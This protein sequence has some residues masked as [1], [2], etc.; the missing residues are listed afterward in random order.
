ME[1]NNVSD[2]NAS[3]VVDQIACT[4]CSCLLRKYRRKGSWLI[5]DICNEYV[6]HV[7]VPNDTDLGNFNARSKSW[8]CE[9]IT[10]HEGPQF[11]LLTISYG[12]QQLISDPTHLLLN[13]STCIDLIFKD[14]T[15]FDK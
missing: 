4:G 8:W 15:K 5:C 10:F 2:G 11:E 13:S 1:N 3:D 9:D 12:L 7:C 14:S 6:C